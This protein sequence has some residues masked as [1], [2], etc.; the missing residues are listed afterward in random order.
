MSIYLILHELICEIKVPGPLICFK[1]VPDTLANLGGGCDVCAIFILPNH[2]KHG[3]N[4]VSNVTNSIHLEGQTKTELSY[5][6]KKKQPGVLGLKLS[7]VYPLKESKMPLKKY[8]DLYLVEWFQIVKLPTC[9]KLQW[10][11]VY[12]L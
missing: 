9:Y 5:P 11:S 7:S 3:D 10:V 6:K 1:A 2:V 12:T 8:Q 4:L